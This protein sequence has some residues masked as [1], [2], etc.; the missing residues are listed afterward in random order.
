MSGLLTRSGV[1][2]LAY[3]ICSLVGMEPAAVRSVISEFLANLSLTPPR[4]RFLEMVID[5]LTSLG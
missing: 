4:I 1:P 5:Q 2:S 3:F